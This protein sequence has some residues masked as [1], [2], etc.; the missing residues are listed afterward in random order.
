MT[1]NH[2]N[3]EYCITGDLNF[4]QAT[5]IFNAIDVAG[6]AEQEININL[7]DIK[8]SDS[9]ALAVMLEWVHQAKAHH[10]SIHFSHVPDQLMRLIN[11]TD[12][13]KLLNLAR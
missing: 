5:E 3:D 7:S 8:Q 4:E 2:N 13:H 12:L 1:V 10:K 6:I 9:A 11:M